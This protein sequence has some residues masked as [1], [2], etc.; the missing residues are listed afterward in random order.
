MVL[1]H[2]NIIVCIQDVQVHGEAGR[3][4]IYGKT[5]IVKNIDYTTARIDLIDD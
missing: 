4:G 1:Y 2:T 3:E 5:T